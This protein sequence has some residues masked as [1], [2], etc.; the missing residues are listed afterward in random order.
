MKPRSFISK[1]LKGLSWPVF[2]VSVNSEL[3]I[4]EVVLFKEVEEEH[5]VHI[6]TVFQHPSLWCQKT[7][8]FD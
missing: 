2:R 1:N 6:Q 3:E 4:N 8:C 5:D 7:V